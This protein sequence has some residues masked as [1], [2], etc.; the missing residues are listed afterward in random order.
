MEEENKQRQIIKLLSEIG[1][2]MTSILDEDELFTFFVSNIAEIL[3]VERVSLM[4]IDQERQELFIKASYG[5]LPPDGSTKKKMG[6]MFGGWVAKHGKPLLVKDVEAEYPDLS[7]EKLA[8]YNS[9]SFVVVPIKLKETVVGILSLTERK[10]NAVFTKSD[11]DIINHIC[12]YLSVHLENIKLLERNA[13]LITFDNLT[14]LLNHRCFQER[15]IDE[16]YRAERYHFPLSLLMLDIDSFAWYNQTYGYSVGD[17]VLRQIGRIIKDN[18]RHADSAARFGTEEFVIV[19]PHTGLEQAVFVGEKIKEI[20]GYSV[21]A[22][23]KT[24]PSGMARITVS[25]GVAE[26]KV[27]VNREELVRRVKEAL[28]Q[29]KKKG[30]NCVC[31]Y[32]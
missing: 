5:F 14:R 11:L 19:L 16:I 6:Q 22:E 28:L 12:H 3:E 31:A 23:D 7:K 9:K 26:H 2:R 25:V 20:I 30:K 15:L 32:K 10:N 21:S 13:S 1:I 24:S 27:G 4:L 18:I 29:A 17:S 8:H